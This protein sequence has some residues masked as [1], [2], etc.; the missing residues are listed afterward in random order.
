MSEARIVGSPEAIRLISFYLPQYHPI[1]EN[2]EWWGRGFTEWRNVVRARPLFKGHYQPRLP[3]DLGFY[4]LRLP[5]TRLAQA[6]L[7]REHGIY[8]FCYYHYWFNGKRLLERPFNEVLH[9]GQPDF[10]FCL[11]WANENW[12]RR[13]D[14][15]E[16]DVLLGQKYSPDD[17]RTHIRALFPAFEDPRYIRVR[18]K[19]LF[20]VYRVGLLPVPKQ[21]AEIWRE[22]AQKAGIGELFLASVESIGVRLPPVETGFD[23]AVEFAPDWLVRGKPTNQGLVSKL[24]RKLGYKDLRPYN[25]YSY[26]TL[27]RN[28]LA[29]RCPPYKQFR[30]VTPS[31]DKTARRQKYADVWVGSSPEKYEAWLSEI[32]EQCRDRL[33]PEERFVFINAWNEWAEGCYLEPDLKYGRAYLEAT[34]RAVYGQ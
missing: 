28:M 32:I 12:T 9:S 1:P 21:T 18:D 23:A 2:D 27:M 25:I 16:Q 5:D 33:P 14:G 15:L 8:G 20:I 11:C 3:A 31:W 10:H 7:A 22:E 19:P 30:C 13:W 26:D 6:E 4:D 34:R 29:K 17:D 24:I